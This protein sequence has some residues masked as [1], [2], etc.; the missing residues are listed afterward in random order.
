MITRLDSQTQKQMLKE[1]L[2]QVTQ[3]GWQNI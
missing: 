3:T 1:T 2:A